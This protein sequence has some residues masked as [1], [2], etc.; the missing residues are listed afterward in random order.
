[1]AT[2]QAELDAAIAVRNAGA[3]R[4]AYEGRTVDYGSVDELTKAINLMRQDL[5]DAANATTATQRI[6]QVQVFSD[7]GF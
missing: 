2:T 4:V 1:M 6:R 5:A 3:L 7:D